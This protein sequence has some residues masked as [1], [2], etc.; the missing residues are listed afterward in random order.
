MT[1]YVFDPSG[2][3]VS[4]PSK[5]VNHHE[6][7]VNQVRGY[8]VVYYRDRGIGYA[9]ASDMDQDDMVRLVSTTLEDD[10]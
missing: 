9:Y 3:E 2:W 10:D 7:Y 5:Q 4:G 1:V 8:N 6:M